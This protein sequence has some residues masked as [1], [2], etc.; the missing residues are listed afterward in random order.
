MAFGQLV[1]NEHFLVQLAGRSL[2]GGLSGGIAAELYGG[3]FGQ[4]FGMGAATAAAGFLFNEVAHALRD[5][6]FV[7][8][9]HGGQ[10]IV[11]DRETGKTLIGGPSE[12]K[13]PFVEATKSLGVDAGKTIDKVLHHPLTEIVDSIPPGEQTGHPGIDKA[14]NLYQIFKWSW[15]K[16]KEWISGPKKED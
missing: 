3:D 14:L 6:F 2:A 10:P 5:R 15:D 1:Q 8:T 11:Y 16:A 9:H 13:D 4:G 7:V 12:Y